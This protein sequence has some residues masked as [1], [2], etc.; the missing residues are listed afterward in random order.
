[1]TDHLKNKSGI[2]EPRRIYPLVKLIQTLI[3]TISS[4]KSILRVLH[5]LAIKWEYFIPYSTVPGLLIADLCV[6]WENHLL[7]AIHGSSLGC[8]VCRIQV[9]KS[10]VML[11]E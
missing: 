3:G 2:C 1:M 4:K 5:K 9:E 10:L 11:F 7:V 6:G 8:F